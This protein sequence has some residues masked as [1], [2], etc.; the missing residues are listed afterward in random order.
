[1]SPLRNQVQIKMNQTASLPLQRNEVVYNP[2]TKS[3]LPKR[4]KNRN[5][6]THTQL[7]F[8]TK[9]ENPHSWIGDP[10]ELPA[11]RQ[12]TRFWFHNCNGMTTANDHI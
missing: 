3:Y 8:H 9:S 6:K 2:Y 11:K 4:I 5:T 7:K 10:I 1:M 12:I